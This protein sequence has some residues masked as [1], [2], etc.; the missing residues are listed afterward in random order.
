MLIQQQ[1]TV[2]IVHAHIN[3]HILS[4]KKTIIANNPA[5]TAWSVMDRLLEVC[6]VTMKTLFS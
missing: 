2:T 4:E 6:W 3:T 1:L 5:C